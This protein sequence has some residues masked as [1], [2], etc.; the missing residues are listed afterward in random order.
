MN[1]NANAGD[2]FVF[3]L[4]VHANAGVC[5]S[6]SAR[7]ACSTADLLPQPQNSA[8]CCYYFKNISLSFFFCLSFKTN[9]FRAL[10]HSLGRSH[11]GY[12]T[13]FT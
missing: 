10:G 9:T 1:E 12:L 11:T 5:E 4:P 3:S 7:T 13:V 8:G 6:E 2:V